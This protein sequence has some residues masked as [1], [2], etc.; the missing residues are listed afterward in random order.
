MTVYLWYWQRTC[1]MIH[2]FYY[3]YSLTPQSYAFL[4][5]SQSHLLVLV[6]GLCLLPRKCVAVFFKLWVRTDSVDHEPISGGPYS[7]QCVFYFWYI[8]L[9][10]AIHCDWI[11]G[12][13]TDLIC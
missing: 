10:A 4:L 13:V 1:T 3:V 6:N 11:W 12:T 9:D 5:R 2:A 8:R 7:Y